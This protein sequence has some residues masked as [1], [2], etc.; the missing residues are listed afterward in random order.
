VNH[1]EAKALVDS[2]PLTPAESLYTRAVALHETHYGDAWK[3]GFGKGSNNMGSVTTPSPDALSFRHGD[4]SFDDTKGAVAPY[5]T[6]F[7]GYPSPLDG[8]K[9]LVR[10]LLKTNVKAAL[11]RGD[12]EG[13]VAAQY[14]KGTPRTSLT[15]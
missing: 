13:A 5:T 15:T 10:T 2:L 11:L 4:S 1:L 7:A 6:W 14:M 8:F 9:G 3:E 12:L